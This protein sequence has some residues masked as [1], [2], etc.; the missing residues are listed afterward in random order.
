MERRN[1]DQRSPQTSK[2]SRVTLTRCIFHIFTFRPPN[3]KVPSKSLDSELIDGH[4]RRA[5]VRSRAEQLRVTVTK[6]LAVKRLQTS[7]VKAAVTSNFRTHNDH[8]IWTSLLTN[9]VSKIHKVSA[10]LELKSF[11]LLQQEREERERLHVS[12]S[13]LAASVIHEAC[14]NCETCPSY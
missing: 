7:S 12:P 10:C 3:F 2:Q 4:L 11:Q 6:R 5:K 1:Q 8:L 14:K 13:K 9:P